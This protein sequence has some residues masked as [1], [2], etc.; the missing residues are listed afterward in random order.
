[1][2]VCASNPTADLIRNTARWQFAGTQLYVAFC[3]ARTT[4]KR[5][6]T[7]ESTKKSWYSQS[8]EFWATNRCMCFKPYRG[9]DREHR[10]MA[11]CWYTTL[12][13]VRFTF[14]L[15]IDPECVRFWPESVN[16]P[17]PTPE[18]REI[19]ILRKNSKKVHF[20]GTMFIFHWYIVSSSPD[21]L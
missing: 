14:E 8:D 20:F 19:L 9:F 2:G 15:R 1:M 10:Q 21:A 7:R 16:A 6:S 13:R 3:D 17:E 4:K 12:C 11:V 18:S 5:V